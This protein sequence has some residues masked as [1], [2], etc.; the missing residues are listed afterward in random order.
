MKE[1]LEDLTEKELKKAKKKAKKKRK[2]EKVGKVEVKGL[3]VEVKGVRV[4]EKG[5]GG[6]EQGNE[7]ARERGNR[8]LGESGA[9][10][11]GEQSGNDEPR[12]TDHQ[13]SDHRPSSTVHRPPITSHSTTSHQPSAFSPLQDA[14]IQA[15]QEAGQTWGLPP[16]M[17]AVHAVLLSRDRAWSTDEVM[18]AL[19]I[20][21]GNAHMQLKALVE[22]GVVHAVRQLGSRRIGYVAERDVWRIATAVAKQRR[23][24]ELQPILEMGKL[25]R[26]HGAASRSM[27]DRA[28]KG[29]MREIVAFGRLMDKLLMETLK[30]DERWWERLVRRWINRS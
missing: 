2:K 16:A 8:E 29:T 4:E 21:R 23:K 26:A 5:E 30:R 18:E 10:A 28:L 17:G 9:A 25:L 1:K 19:A 3:R 24:R 11:A 7:G 13:P 27:D 6:K 15:W 22:W 20:S 14:F 12:T